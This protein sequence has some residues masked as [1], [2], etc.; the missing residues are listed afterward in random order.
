MI[1]QKSHEVDTKDWSAEGEPFVRAVRIEQ[2]VES[3]QQIYYFA[4]EFDELF[5]QYKYA[6]TPTSGK[7]YHWWLKYKEEEIQGLGSVELAID[8]YIPKGRVYPSPK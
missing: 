7:R 2:A 5:R 4:D 3:K 6:W 1:Y 8:K